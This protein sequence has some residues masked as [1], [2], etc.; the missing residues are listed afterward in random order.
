SQLTTSP[1]TPGGG[2]AET[3]GQR[4]EESP[5]LPSP[6]SVVDTPASTESAGASPAAFEPGPAAFE[7]APSAIPRAPASTRTFD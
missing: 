1:A 2:P 3:I 6:A 5:A 7:P 4:L